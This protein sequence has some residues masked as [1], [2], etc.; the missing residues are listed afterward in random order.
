MFFVFWIIYR[1]YHR[2]YATQ[3]LQINL[4][5]QISFLRRSYYPWE[6]NSKYLK[7][8]DLFLWMSFWNSFCLLFFCFFCL[9]A[10]KPE[11]NLSPNNLPPP[12]IILTPNTTMIKLCYLILIPPFGMNLLQLNNPQLFYW[13]LH[14]IFHLQNHFTFLYLPCFYLSNT[15]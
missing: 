1:V 11:I 3:L 2:A 13:L 4:H 5:G 15:S 12:D 6:I 9:G 10:L 14:L 7:F 8:Y